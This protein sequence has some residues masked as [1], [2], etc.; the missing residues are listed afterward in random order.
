LK[1]QVT[2]KIKRKVK[3]KVVIRAAE[4]QDPAELNIRWMPESVIK[5][6]FYDA[7]TKCIF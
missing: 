7:D 3:S 1:V 4:G 2:N 6:R 5:E